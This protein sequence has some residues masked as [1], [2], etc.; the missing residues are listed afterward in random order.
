M[1]EDERRAP[2]GLSATDGKL[3]GVNV[4]ASEEEDYIQYE[5]I[6]FELDI[7]AL[8]VLRSGILCALNYLL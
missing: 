2:L 5:S 3:N 1:L 7:P 4:V 6:H 8:A